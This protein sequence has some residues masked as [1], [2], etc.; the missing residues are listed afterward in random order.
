MPSSPHAK[1]SLSPLTPFPL[2]PL[3]FGC[4]VTF[5]GGCIS[6]TPG[7]NNAHFGPAVLPPYPGEARQ[8]SKPA[9][10]F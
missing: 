1:G 10:G 4:H 7:S 8:Q 6:G 5:Q 9:G 3:T 2:K